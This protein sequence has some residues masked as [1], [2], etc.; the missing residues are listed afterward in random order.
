MFENAE[1]LSGLERLKISEKLVLRCNEKSC[2]S[3]FPSLDSA[4]TPPKKPTV[5]PQQNKML[6]FEMMS[7]LFIFLALFL[8]TNQ[9]RYYISKQNINHCNDIKRPTV[10]RHYF[11][12]MDI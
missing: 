7:P 10:S 3:I 12:S 2:Y 1:F 6:I 4:P 5:K 11:Y 9:N 8:F